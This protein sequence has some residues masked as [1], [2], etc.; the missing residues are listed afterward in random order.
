MTYTV[1]S[2][3]LNSSI[4]CEIWKSYF[5]SLRQDDDVRNVTDSTCLM[6]SWNSRHKGQNNC[7]KWPHCAWTEASSLFRHRSIASSTTLCRKQ[8]TCSYISVTSSDG[9][10]LSR[11]CILHH[12]PDAVINRIEVP[13][14]LVGHMLGAVNSG[15]SRRHSFTIRRAR[16]A[17]A[18]SK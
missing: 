3:T 18:S 17:G 13:A 12:S 15:V 11:F 7:S 9:V 5:S 16:L 1:S 10:W 4:P 6:Q 8:S 14:V 2:G